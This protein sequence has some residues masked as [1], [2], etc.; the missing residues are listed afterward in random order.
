LSFFTLSPKKIT[1]LA[2]GKFDGLHL[3]HKSV[4][5]VLGQNGGVL[6]IDNDDSVLTPFRYRER[7]FSVPFFY[8]KLGEI[9][10]LEGGEFIAKLKKDFPSLS[11]IVVGYDFMFGKN[12][13]FCAWDIEELFEGTAVIV[14]EVKLEGISVHSGVIKELL[15]HGD[16]KKANFLLGR[17]YEIYGVQ[18]AGQGIGKKELYATINIDPKKF[19]LPQEGVFV[20]K[21]VLGAKEYRS[22]T[23]LG[24]RVS[25]DRSFSVE[26]H[27]V[28]DFEAFDGEVGVRFY[29][30]IRDNM[31]FN[32]LKLLKDR[33]EADINYARQYF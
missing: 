5:D 4:I 27:I 23:F 33:I 16:I 13:S 29:E 7:V 21:T 31:K 2:I 25:T 10:E 30:K 24:H 19:L 28:E 32:D 9:K 18:V 12:R 22:V 8:Y 1:A 11:K 17:E 15:K 14:P 3:G 20:T 6:V 26:T